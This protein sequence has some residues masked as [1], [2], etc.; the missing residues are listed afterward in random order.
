LHRQP[1]LAEYVIERAHD[2]GAHGLDSNWLEVNMNEAFACAVRGRSAQRLELGAVA[3]NAEHRMRHQL[4][5]E[6][7]LGDFAHHRI[8]QERHVVIDD[9]DQRDRLAVARLIQRHVLAADFRRA[10]LAL[11]QKIERSLGQR[12]E[13]GRRVAQHVFRHRVLVKLR[14]ERGRDVVA[15]RAE[16]RARLFDHGAGGAFAFADGNIHGHGIMHRLPDSVEHGLGLSH[17]VAGDREQH[18]IW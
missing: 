15:A 6:P 17:S 16:R 14:D 8:D 3:L 2:V 5:G 11:A 7:A 18:T 4:H 1:H 13:I 12:G 9:L 10:R